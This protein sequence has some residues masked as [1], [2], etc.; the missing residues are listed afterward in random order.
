MSA[1]LSNYL[2]LGDQQTSQINNFSQSLF[3]SVLNLLKLSANAC[4]ASPL[5][6]S[7]SLL[8][9]KLTLI[10]ILPPIALKLS[11]C[12]EWLRMYDLNRKP[13]LCEN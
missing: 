7:S 13:S 10:G 11:E 5:S 4:R 6:S 12:G 3:D 8:F 9:T 2:H 1:A